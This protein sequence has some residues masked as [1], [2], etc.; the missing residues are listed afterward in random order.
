MNLYKVNIKLSDTEHARCCSCEKNWKDLFTVYPHIVPLAKKARWKVP[1]L[2]NIFA[3]EFGQ[4]V[5]LQCNSCF[6]DHS[7]I[8]FAVEFQPDIAGLPGKNIV[9][10]K[11]DTL[12]SF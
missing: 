8:L 10:H 4:A 11:L 3:G 6:K 5:A 12:E 9:Y 7:P 1:A 2:G